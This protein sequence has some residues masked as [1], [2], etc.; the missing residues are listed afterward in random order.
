MDCSELALAFPGTA[1]AAVSFLDM[2]IRLRRCPDVSVSLER[3]M[4][5]LD[6]HE[7]LT[8]AHL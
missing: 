2:F 1:A 7:C 4:K 8:S 3:M 5:Y 6:A